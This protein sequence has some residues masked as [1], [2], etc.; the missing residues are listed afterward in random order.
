MPG[1][2]PGAASLGWQDAVCVLDMRYPPVYGR[3]G[4]YQHASPSH[5]NPCC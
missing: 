3:A 2:L 4:M 1:D 5:H